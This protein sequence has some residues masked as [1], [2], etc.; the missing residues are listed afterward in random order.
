M[1][2]KIYKRNCNIVDTLVQFLSEKK[3]NKDYVIKT[4]ISC[5]RPPIDEQREMVSLPIVQFVLIETVYLRKQNVQLGFNILSKNYRAYPKLFKF[6]EGK[7]EFIS[8]VINHVLSKNFYEEDKR[9]WFRSLQ[10]FL[11]PICLT[12][13]CSKYH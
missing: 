8:A 3:N 11:V 1:V 13:Y 7:K 2:I 9:G 10:N 5:S 4:I 12:D 6:F